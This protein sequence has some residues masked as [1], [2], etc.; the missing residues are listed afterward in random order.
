MSFSGVI[1]GAGQARTNTLSP[2]VVSVPQQHETTH[3]DPHDAPE[4][5]KARTPKPSK[6][7]SVTQSSDTY[8]TDSELS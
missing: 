7:P 5:L 2:K 8:Y 3:G 1:Y 6:R 4:C